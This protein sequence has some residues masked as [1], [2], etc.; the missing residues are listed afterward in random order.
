MKDNFM[1]CFVFFCIIFAF[2][3][4]VGFCCISRNI[5][6]TANQLEIIKTELINEKESY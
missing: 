6:K 4:L 1:H 2:I 3:F 5:K